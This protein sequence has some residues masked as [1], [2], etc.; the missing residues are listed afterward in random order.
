LEEAC[1]VGGKIQ[2]E[3]IGSSV[4]IEDEGS[5]QYVAVEGKVVSLQGEDSSTSRISPTA[6]FFVVDKQQLQ[7]L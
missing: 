5:V 3:G 1:V 4:G 2:N 6:L 7:L